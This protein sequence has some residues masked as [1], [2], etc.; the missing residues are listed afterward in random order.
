MVREVLKDWRYKVAF[1]S[2]VREKLLDWLGK[3]PG[4]RLEC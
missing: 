1:L 2:K 4:G 3:L